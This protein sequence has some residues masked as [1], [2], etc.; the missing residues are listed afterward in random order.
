MIQ[1]LCETCTHAKEIFSGNGSRFL[2][3]EKSQTDRRFEKYP[4]Q[5]V[6][7]HDLQA[8]V[9]KAHQRTMNLEKLFGFLWREQHRQH[10]PC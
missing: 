10:L 2:L 3:C 4:P 9:D 8:L 6:A 7:G 1:S 5:P